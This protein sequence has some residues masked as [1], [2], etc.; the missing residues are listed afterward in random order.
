MDELLIFFGGFLVGG[1]ITAIGFQIYMMSDRKFWR[2][3]DEK[4]A[5]LE[6]EDPG[7]SREGEARETSQDSKR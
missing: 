1:I 4:I 3:I 6:R 2:E 5:R 7:N